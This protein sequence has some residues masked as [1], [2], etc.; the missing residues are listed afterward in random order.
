ML[1]LISPSEQLKWK[2][3]SSDA[4]FI[5]RR[6]SASEYRSIEKVK[7]SRGLTDYDEVGFEVV[8]RCLIGWENVVDDTMKPVTYDPSLVDGLPGGI[9][10]M[11]FIE[12]R[13]NTGLSEDDE[14][15]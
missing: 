1:K 10:N 4:V 3:P 5:F 9:I 14:K 8:K 7:T 12:I 13:S 6:I 11:L 2:D 15:K